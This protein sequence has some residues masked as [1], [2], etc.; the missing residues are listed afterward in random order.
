MERG[1]EAAVA[2][3]LDCG[4]QKEAEPGK[5]HRYYSLVADRTEAVLVEVVRL[6]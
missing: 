4:R 6:E 2:A 3:L 5:S 1:N